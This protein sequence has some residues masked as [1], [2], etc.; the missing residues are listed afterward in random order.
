MR[1]VSTIVANQPPEPCIDCGQPVGIFLAA[2]MAT[3]LIL[4]DSTGVIIPSGCRV[5]VAHDTPTGQRCP[6]SY[7]D[8][9]RRAS[10]QSTPKPDPPEPVG[11]SHGEDPLQRGFTHAL[12]GMNRY[13]GKVD[14]MRWRVRRDEDAT[15]EALYWNSHNG[16]VVQAYATLYTFADTQTVSLSRIGKC[17]WEAA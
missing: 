15:G 4:S 13:L 3:Q 7:A 2:G 10:D 5:R 8:P 17:H 1:T 11:P 6:G 14:T 9:A 16:W 12:Q